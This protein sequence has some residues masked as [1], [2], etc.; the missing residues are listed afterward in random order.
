MACRSSGC[1]VQNVLV[2]VTAQIRH[3]F[4]ELRDHVYQPL[5]V[6]SDRFFVEL[7]VRPFEVDERISHVGEFSYPIEVSAA[8]RRQFKQSKKPRSL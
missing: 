7:R 8:E 5:S 6:A 4:L 3:G 1:G 2:L